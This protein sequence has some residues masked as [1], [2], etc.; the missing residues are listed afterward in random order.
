MPKFTEL[1]LPPDEKIHKYAKKIGWK[2]TNRKIKTKFLNEKDWGELK[3]QIRN[4]EDNELLIHQA[5]RDEKLLRKISQQERIDILL[6]LGKKQR[7]IPINHKT[8]ENLSKNNIAIALNL[9]NL[10]KQKKEHKTNTLTKWTKIRE[11]SQKHQ[12]P[13]ILT[14]NAQNKYQLRTPRDLKHFLKTLNYNPKNLLSQNPSK[15][16]EMKKTEEK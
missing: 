10:T 8:A 16:L 13:V 6:N 12:I 2:H 15:I 11:I 3:K 1:C 7:N 5:K 4:A 14:T 9:R